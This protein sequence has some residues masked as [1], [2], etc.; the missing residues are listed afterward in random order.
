MERTIAVVGIA[1]CDRAIARARNDVHEAEWVGTRNDLSVKS[2]GL[3]CSLLYFSVDFSF[4][5]F[6][7]FF[8]LFF[9]VSYN[10]EIGRAHV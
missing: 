7:P 4:L 6:T 3:G 2:M 1:G 9:V 5:P 8:L 10:S